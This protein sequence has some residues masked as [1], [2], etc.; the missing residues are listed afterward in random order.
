MIMHT[1]IRRLDA[2]H[3]TAAE[4]AAVAQPGV[5][6]TGLSRPG[7]TTPPPAFFEAGDGSLCI[8]AAPSRHRGNAR[9]GHSIS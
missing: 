5:G 7:S 4:S 3:R 9:Q 8:A 2:G 6:I 1:A